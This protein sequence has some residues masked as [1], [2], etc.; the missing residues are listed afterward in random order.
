[1]N[2]WNR[3]G[4]QTKL[5]VLV[6]IFL[7]G[8]LAFGFLSQRT[9]EELRIN[10]P[11]YHRIILRDDLQAQVGSPQ[12]TLL[13]PYLTV[14][15]LED[16][17]NPARQAALVARIRELQAEFE[18]SREYWNRVLPEGELK[19]GLA[20]NA[21][22][23]Q[24]FYRMVNEQ[25]LPALQRKD[26]AALTRIAESLR[27]FYEASDAAL[28]PVAKLAREEDQASEKAATASLHNGNNQLLILGVS[29]LVVSLLAGLGI[30]RS[31]AVPLTAAVDRAQS[32]SHGDLTQPPLPVKTGDETGR[33]ASTFNT[34]TANLAVMARQTRS[35]TGDLNAAVA[36]IL[37]STQEQAASTAEQSAAVQETTATMEEISQSGAQI[38]ERARQVAASAEAT[39]T[40]S[41]A[42]LAAVRGVRSSMA[43]IQEQ[44]GAV[45]ENIVDLSARTQAVGEIVASVTQIAEQSNLLA[46][47][48]AIEAAAAGEHGRSFAVVASEM[49]NLAEQSKQA[50]VQVR[51]ILG[52]IQKGINTSVMLT[53]EA[54]KRVE[55]G[56]QQADVAEHTIQEMA[57]N[58]VQSIQAF[59]QIVAA[60]NQ[61]Q[62]GFDQVTRAVQN[63]R[64]AS[65]QTAISTR[66][67]EQAA[68]NMGDLGVKLQSAVEAYR[69]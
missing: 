15:V 41:N 33:L 51:S 1:M 49:K 54:V 35:I 47:N 39:S 48:A 65:E 25:F 50:T 57:Q 63:I 8:F 9:L 27:S 52:E 42:G 7:A 21:V 58:I 29:L 36:Q 20:R 62:I 22:P 67:L 64:D 5:L 14:H 66:Q 2:W 30:A 11:L 17:L 53:E 45:A 38:S 34:M 69:V 60:T 46:L 23:I 6:G 31:I 3:I 56:R 16:E 24:Q 13:E 55:S 43:G 4:I 12:L 59:Q 40:T 37:A 32:L 10:G 44:A 68:G 28:A 18:T 61:Q 26:A 19:Q